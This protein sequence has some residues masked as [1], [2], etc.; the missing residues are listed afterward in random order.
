[1]QETS[2]E[3]GSA[4]AEVVD[5]GKEPVEAGVPMTRLEVGVDNLAEVPVGMPAEALVGMPAEAPVEARVEAP[6]DQLPAR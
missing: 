2:F 5:M 1:M 4:D 6:V 3:V